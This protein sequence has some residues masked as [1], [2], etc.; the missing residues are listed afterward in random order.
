MAEQLRLDKY[1][2]EMGIGTRSELK[3]WIRKGRVKI[4]GEICNKPEQKVDALAD[5]ICF[6]DSRIQ[7]SKYVYYMLHKPAGV[8]SATVDNVSR[9]VLDLIKDRQG[10]DL[11]PVGRLDKDT[12]GLLL[13]TNDGDLAHQLLSP[14]KH[15]DK[16]YYAKVKGKV[17]EEDGKAFSTGVDIGEDSL[18]LP[19]KLNIL[20]SAEISEVELTIQEGK[21]HQVK[22]MFE[23][24]GKEV[25]YLK[26][27]SMGSLVLDPVL[28]PG[29]YRGLTDDELRYLKE[30]NQ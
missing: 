27:L 29:E 14:R 13:I 1:L 7:Y 17:T 12:E 26:R 8:V 24:I 21:F 10:K 6:D 16:V 5:V 22:R 25:I 19:A 2:A 23:A 20:K 4:N 3:T 15:V 30:L 28:A 9:T 18:T 11:F